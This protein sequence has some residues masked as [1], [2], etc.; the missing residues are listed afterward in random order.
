[1]GSQLTWQTDSEKCSGVTDTGLRP[2]R[3]F[4]ILVV[5]GFGLRMAYG[6]GRYRSDLIRLSGP[7]FIV[8][9]NF[10]ALEHVLIAKAL[11]S[12]Q[13]YVVDDSLALNGRHVSYRGKEAIFKA[14]LYEF[15]LAGVFAISGFSFLLFFPLQA[16]FGGVLSGLVGLVA[17]ET[18]RK[19]GA[20]LLA[21]LGAAANPVLVSSASQPYN[22]N[23]F[24]LLFVASIWAFFMW[25]RTGHVP[26]ALLCGGTIGLCILTRENG[27][28]LLAAIGVVGLAAV[29]RNYPLWTGLV[30]I[31]VI[32]VL[33]VAPWTIRNYLRF[34]TIVPVASIVGTDLAAGNNECVASESLGT[35]YWAEGP[36]ASLSSRRRA[37]LAISSAAS[38][39]PAAVLYDRVSARVALEFIGQHPGAYAKLCLRRLWTSLLPFNPRGKQRRY[40]RIVSVLYWIAVFPAGIAGIVFGWKQ[41]DSRHALLIGLIALNLLSIAAVLYWSDLRFR[42]G[43]DLLL[44]CFA[45]MTYEKYL[46]AA[47]SGVFEPLG[48]ALVGRTSG[49]LH[50][51]RIGTTKR[52]PGSRP[53][54][55]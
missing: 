51:L 47:N 15:F 25:L 41:M 55:G 9:W 52:T 5:L 48:A 28:T 35:P 1:M 27:I 45:A 22:E 3:L 2:W 42:V 18:F 13:G 24:F 8:S 46:D 30:A 14:P 49:I 10:D 31:V 33:I 26:W 34:G 39:I 21:G 19:P 38:R 54:S 23:L 50:E 29:I 4:V 17:L 6:I 36:C 16:M 44:G 43:V 11:L 40:W 53:H 32:S 12:G 20:A 37:Q 7:E